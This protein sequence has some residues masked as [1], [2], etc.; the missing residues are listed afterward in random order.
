M[1]VVPTTLLSLYVQIFA[2][3]GRAPT[4]LAFLAAESA[5]TAR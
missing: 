3:W 1:Y 2:L 4:S 5:R